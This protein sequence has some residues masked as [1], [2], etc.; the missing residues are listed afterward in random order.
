[1][2]YENYR[3]GSYRHLPDVVKNLLIINIIL[4]LATQFF[5][6]Q[7]LDLTD[8]LGLHYFG[9]EKFRVYQIVTYM[10]MHDPGGLMHI[11]FNM[12]AL[13]MFGGAIENVW[14]PKK[15]L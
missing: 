5:M 8:I 3:P 12:L 6:S 14:G 10:F 15:F 9:S 7:G 1:M 2:N 13:Y 4:Y 11:F